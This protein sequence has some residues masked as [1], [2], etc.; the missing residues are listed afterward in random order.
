MQT[1]KI[2]H[3]TCEC[4]PENSNAVY[5]ILSPMPLDSHHMEGIARL[6]GCNIAVI[7]GM[8]WDNDMTPWEAPG[9]EPGDA[10][11]KGDAQKFLSTLVT[12]VLP[13]I[14]KAFPLTST[15]ERNLVGIS[16]SGLFTLWAWLQGD[17]FEN[18][19]CISASF[20]YQGFAAWVASLKIPQKQGCAYFSLGEREKFSSNP[21]FRPVE[22]D[23][24]AIVRTLR[25]EGL[26]VMFQSTPGNHYASVYPRLDKLFNA[27]AGTASPI[28]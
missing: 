12:E 5:Y 23:T 4:Y 7:Y 28:M 15:P 27:L 25:E 17:T 16:L 22:T 13:A 26:C 11:F 6:H 18:I 9:V 19:G 3:L 1:L 21:W 14:E 2:R 20:W 24:M 8:D 10:P